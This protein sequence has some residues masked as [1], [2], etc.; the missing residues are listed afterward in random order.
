VQGV[1]ASDFWAREGEVI[2]IQCAVLRPKVHTL[3]SDARSALQERGFRDLVLNRE[4][5][6]AYVLAERSGADVY[7]NADMLS[8]YRAESVENPS[9]RSSRIASGEKPTAVSFKSEGA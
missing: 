2:G 1:E 9:C 6:P 7:K 8:Q 3:T 5:R 4:C